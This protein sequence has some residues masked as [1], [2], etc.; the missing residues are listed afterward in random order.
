MM[1][2]VAETLQR[3]ARSLHSHS[4]SPRLAAELLLAKPLGLS[5]ANG[6]DRLVH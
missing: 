5:P 2:T 4:E 6:S 1:T 3:A